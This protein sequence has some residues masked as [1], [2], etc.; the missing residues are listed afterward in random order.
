MRQAKKVAF[1]AVLALSVVGVL[2]ISL[3]RLGARAMPD[4]Q[5][6][7]AGGDVLLAPLIEADTVTTEHLSGQEAAEYLAQSRLRFLAS[8]PHLRWAG[9]EPTEEVIV[10]QRDHARP[11]RFVGP[12]NAGS[13]SLAQSYVSNSYG[14]L[15]L[16]SWDD[17]DDSTWEG[18]ILVERYS[19]GSW[20]TWE[21]QIDISTTNYTTVW[22]EWTGGEIHEEYQ[23]RKSLGSGDF[24]LAA[25][26]GGGCGPG[27]PGGTYATQEFQDF[28][29]CYLSGCSGVAAACRMLG[30]AWGNCFAAGCAGVVIDCAI[31][32]LL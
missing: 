30:P 7:G 18:V 19:D 11:A 17:G 13:Y 20:S 1:S 31:D 24:R 6:N 22:A 29:Q 25:W 32:H 27:C 16:W 3:Q 21:T 2:L 12:G 8:G 9:A 5:V 23:T 10:L 26:G 15:T 28:V 4:A 14:G